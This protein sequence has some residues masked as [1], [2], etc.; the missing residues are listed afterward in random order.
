MSVCVTERERE[1]E[2]EREGESVQAP[3]E[4]LEGVTVITAMYCAGIITS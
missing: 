1:R 2:R 3:Y 4:L